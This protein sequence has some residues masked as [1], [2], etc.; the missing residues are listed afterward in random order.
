MNSLPAIAILIIG[1]AAASAESTTE[2]LA[3]QVTNA[4]EPW[5]DCGPGSWFQLRTRS[6]TGDTEST[7]E[8]RQTLIS[9]DEKEVKIETRDVKRVKDADGKVTQQMGEPH[10]TISPVGSM[11]VR[12]EDVKELEGETI[13][14]GERTF[15]C[16]VIQAKCVY[17]F[18]EPLMGKSEYTWKSKMWISNQVQ[19]MGGLVKAE[20]DIE[21]QGQMLCPTAADLTLVESG[22]V[23]M[24]GE[25]KFRCSIYRSGQVSGKKEENPT[26]GECWTSS[27]S[28]LGYVRATYN[29]RLN[30]GGMK[31]TTVVETEITGLEIVAPKKD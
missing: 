2:E 29:I 23:V 12:L 22:K 28:P 26:S 10:T 14:A 24:V 20:T 5:K 18:P 9:R 7:S 1:A 8:I 30:M 21:Q 3:R 25:R 4:Y 19:E 27:E 15:I 6:K 11:G 31:S 13:N 17:R 16:R